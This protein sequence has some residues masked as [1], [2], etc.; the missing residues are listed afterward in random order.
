MSR[1]DEFENLA[2]QIEETGP[3][4]HNK[5]GAG[6][7]RAA[8]LQDERS[9]ELVEKLG[10]LK[11]QIDDSATKMSEAADRLATGL[12]SVKDAVGKF[13]A[14]SGKLTLVVIIVAVA[15]ALANIVYAGTYVYT[16][17]LVGK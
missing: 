14:D 4:G 3:G 10:T 9:E 16:V 6:Q 8:G 13:N 5:I 17:F 11:D 2:K 7:V 12:A 15:S 1:K